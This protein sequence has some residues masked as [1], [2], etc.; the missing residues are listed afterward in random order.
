MAGIVRQVRALASEAHPLR[1]GHLDS[2]DSGECR[3]PAV[4]VTLRHT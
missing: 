1:V 2:E 3:R 4:G